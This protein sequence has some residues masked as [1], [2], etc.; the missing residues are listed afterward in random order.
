MLIATWASISTNHEITIWAKNQHL[1][2]AQPNPLSSAWI[3]QGHLSLLSPSTGPCISGSFSG[4]PTQSGQHPVSRICLL[5]SCRSRTSLFKPQLLPKSSPRTPR[6]RGTS[7][8]TLLGC[9]CACG[10][11]QTFTFLSG[12]PTGHR[13]SV[14]VDYTSSREPSTGWMP[15]PTRWRWEDTEMRTLKGNVFCW[16]LENLRPRFFNRAPLYT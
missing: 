5:I 11:F 12:F 14:S 16:F 6:L 13:N 3:A 2:W 7:F 9:L 15:G 8:P 1:I 10:I 4:L